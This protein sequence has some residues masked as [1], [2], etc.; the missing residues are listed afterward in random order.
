LNLKKLLFPLLAFAVPMLV[1]FTP[2]ALMGQYIVGFDTM[3]HYVPTTLLWLDGQVSLWSFI[4][5]APLLY[6][7]TAGLT[8]ASGSVLIVLKVLAPILL[9]FL[10]L[11]MYWY[12]RRGLAWSPSK[13]LIPAIVGTIYFVALRISWDALREEIAVIFFFVALT[14]IAIAPPTKKFS[15][16]RYLPLSGALIA[17]VLSNQV[18]SV[19][20]MGVVLFTV[21][22]KLF[23]KERINAIRLVAFTLPAAALFLVVF[24]LS[25]SIPEY[26]L[27]FGFPSTPDSWLSLFGYTSYQSMLYSEAWFLLY[28]FVPLLPLALLG[29]RHFKNFQLRI[30]IGLILLAAFVPIVSPS[31]PRL[32]MLI[33][34][35]LVF[36]TAEGLSRLKAVQWKRFGKPLLGAGMVYLASVTA[37]FSL[38]FMTYSPAAP[39]SYFAAEGSNNHIYQIPSSMLQNTVS[40]DDCSDTA[41]TVQWLKTNMDS[42][43]VLLSHRVLYGWAL[44][45]LNASQVIL[46]EYDNPAETAGN[47]PGSYSHVYLIWWINGEGWHGLPAVPPVFHQVYQSGNMAVY[48]YTST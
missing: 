14:V 41:N 8:L 29:V 10:G 20:A 23:R 22:Y 11:S 34:Y 46:Y 40:I 44:L 48:T 16:K 39:F 27:I 4:A 42:N 31:N 12:A 9:G 36:F 33:S 5:T 21:I 45:E 47:L 1:R 2:E 25:P 6:T 35:P 32:L 38:G 7:I 28:C 26:R 13:S 30:W 18:V 37:V 3:A 24:Y 43:S 15:W 19:L 17:V